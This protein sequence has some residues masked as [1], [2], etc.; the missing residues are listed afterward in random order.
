M[1]KDCPN[2]YKPFGCA[3]NHINI[4]EVI[5]EGS[6]LP[7]EMCEYER[8][9]FERCYDT[10]CSACHLKGRAEFVAS[11]KEERYPSM[12]DLVQLI[13][14]TRVYNKGTKDA[15]CY[16][17]TPHHK[18]QDEHHD[19]QAEHHDDDMVDSKMQPTHKFDFPNLGDVECP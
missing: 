16:T 11:K 3:L 15:R 14:P 6:E 7:K 17:P 13:A 19:E 10:R 18:H 2:R 9:P 5:E 1:G 8:F 4:G 12:N